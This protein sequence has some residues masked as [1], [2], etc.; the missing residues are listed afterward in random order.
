[1]AEAQAVI[2]ELRAAGMGTGQIA[3]AAQV[4]RFTVN[5]VE[6]GLSPTAR[7]S[8]MQRLRAA[9]RDREVAA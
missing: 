2:S 4:S 3:A 1:M 9:L 8:T 6:Q 5:R 7:L